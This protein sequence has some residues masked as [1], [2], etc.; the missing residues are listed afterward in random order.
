MRLHG[1]R[2][3]AGFSLLEAI[4]ALTIF[5][6]CAMAL[7]AWMS[8]NQTTLVRVQARDA[9]VRDGRAALA[10]LELVNPMAEPTGNRKLPGGLEVRWSSS[11]IVPRAPGMGASG[12]ML[13]FDLALYEMEVSALRKGREVTRFKM[14]RAG[15]KTARTMRDDNF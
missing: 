13:A 7:Y 15:W 14:R 12:N 6:I 8:V 11:E 2:G 9:A 4:V 5:S 1:R 10:V 3:Q